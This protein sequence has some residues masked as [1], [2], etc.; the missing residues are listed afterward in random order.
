MK[1]CPYCA[2]EIQDAAIICKHCKSELPPPAQ[3][4]SA[5]TPEAEA[6]PAPTPE[7]EPMPGPEPAP[8]VTQAS[9]PPP[10]PPPA[11]VAQDTTKVRSKAPM[12]I[13]GVAA[14]LLVLAG[15]A[16]LLIRANTPYEFTGRIAPPAGVG[17]STSEECDVK[18]G[19]DA[20]LSVTANGEVVGSGLLDSAWEDGQCFGAFAFSIDRAD[21]YDTTLKLELADGAGGVEADGPSFTP[22]DLNDAPDGMDYTFA[23]FPKAQTFIDQAIKDAS[24]EVAQ[25]GLLKSLAAAT[26]IYT[27]N[28]SYSGTTRKAMADVD[29]SLRYLD[30][31]ASSTGPSEISI[32]VCTQ[33][34]CYVAAA[35]SESGTCY[36][37]RDDAT[38]GTLFGTGDAALCSAV[39]ANDG[40]T[41]TEW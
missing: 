15:G 22:S 26:V 6:I 33:S 23:D 21:S 31:D 37:L 9:A 36:Y 2:E 18:S 16:F 14:L 5:P 27:A 1:Q 13:G 24:D 10:E 30:F 12:I 17:P 8:E 4:T 29:P 34:D 7:P 32:G 40:A 28:D 20:T 19:N 11:P 39:D 35:L 38:D 3:P 25:S 41:D